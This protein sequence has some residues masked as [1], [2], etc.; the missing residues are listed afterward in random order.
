MVKS[1]GT[2]RPPSVES[3][4]FPLCATHTCVATGGPLRGTHIDALPATF[5]DQLC[6]NVRP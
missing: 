2:F 6:V 5:E 4:I 1:G 3:R